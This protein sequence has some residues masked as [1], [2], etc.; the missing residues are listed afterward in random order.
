MKL[1]T[2]SHRDGGTWSKSLHAPLDLWLSLLQAFMGY[3]VTCWCGVTGCL[4]LRETFV[5]RSRFGS[6]AIIGFGCEVAWYSKT[7]SSVD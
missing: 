6:L 4:A 3:V 2:I 5:C 1:C 7:V